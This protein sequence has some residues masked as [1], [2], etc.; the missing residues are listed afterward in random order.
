MKPKLLL[1][2]LLLFLSFVLKVNGQD[3]WQTQNS[4]VAANLLSVSF[5]D[6]LHGWIAAD[7]GILL[8]TYDGGLNWSKANRP[9]NFIPSKIFFIDPNLGWLA[10]EYSNKADTGF[11]LR[12]SDGGQSWDP[13]F[14]YQYFKFNDLFFINDT[15][16][17]LTGAELSGDDRLSLIMHTVNGGDNWIM[18]QSPRIMDELYSIHFR[19]TDYG[20]A[21]GKDGVFFTTNNGGRNEISGWA[22]SISIPS[23]GMDLY[24]I[25]NAADN[26]GCAVGEAGTVIFTKDKWSNHLKYTT[27]SEDTL[28]AVTGLQDGTGY[29]AVGNNGCMVG[30]HYSILGVSLL[31][32][33]R[34]TTSNL[35]DIVAVNDHHIWAVGENGTILFYGK[36]PTGI[37]DESTDQPYRVYPNPSTEYL[38]IEAPAGS[39]IRLFN[40]LGVCYKEKVITVNDSYMNVSDLYEGVYILEINYKERH[41]INK[42]LIR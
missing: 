30:V 22:M 36:N 27:T 6:S 17:W 16:G 20:Q 42:I 33:N 4:P 25:Y 35:N 18:P 7:N 8:S 21:C 2:S 23:Y 10:G 1:F 32:D 24:D 29:W 19:D 26:Y 9:E 34:I 40:Y 31:E 13:V 15:M 41:I 37:Q 3:T 14:H 28:R 39:Y 11:V 12:T 38:Y 5:A